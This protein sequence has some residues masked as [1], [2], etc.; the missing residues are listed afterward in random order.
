VAE[1]RWV[2]VGLLRGAGLTVASGL[3]PAEAPRALRWGWWSRSV[4]G[5]APAGELSQ[6]AKSGWAALM[7]AGEVP[8]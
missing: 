6:W 5:W 1:L 8:G 4:V 7:L 2:V 3:L